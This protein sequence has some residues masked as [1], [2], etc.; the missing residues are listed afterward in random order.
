[1]EDPKFNWVV[2]RIVQLK[3]QTHQVSYVKFRALVGKKWDLRLRVGTS[4]WIQKIEWP[5]LL[6]VLSDTSLRSDKISLKNLV[7]L[8]TGNK[9]S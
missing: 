6:G 2:K 7:T 5:S 4:T 9:H 8:K 1:M 3:S